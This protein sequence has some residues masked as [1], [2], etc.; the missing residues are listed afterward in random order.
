MDAELVAG[1][2]GGAQLQLA[3][4][5]QLHVADVARERRRH[6][7]HLRRRPALEDAV[8]HRQLRPQLAA[9]ALGDVMEAED[10][11]ELGG[12][13][14]RALGRAK[15]QDRGVRPPPVRRRQLKEELAVL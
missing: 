5:R 14:D 1:G 12:D 4:E 6:R 8:P 10:A 3:L 9:A 13:A 11:E 15:V 2:E 7:L